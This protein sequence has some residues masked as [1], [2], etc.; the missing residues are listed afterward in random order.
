MGKP[1]TSILGCTASNFKPPPSPAPIEDCEALLRHADMKRQADPLRNLP[2]HCRYGLNH[3]RP[4]RA[5]SIR[6][7]GDADAAQRI[8]EIP[9]NGGRQTGRP[10][11]HFFVVLSV[12]LLANQP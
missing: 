2:R 5:H 4:L 6:R 3:L 11:F 9:K 10:L 7:S 1:T 12:A 8:A